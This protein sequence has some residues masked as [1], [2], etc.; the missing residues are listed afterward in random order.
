M[1]E[2]KRVIAL[3]FFDGVHLAHARLLR[4]VQNR[5]KE[6]GAKPC[7]FTFDIH[8]SLRLTGVQEPLLSS[9]EDR[10]QMMTQLFGMEEVIVASFDQ[11]MSMPWEDFV[12]VYLAKEQNAAHVVCGYDFRFGSHGAGDA[13]KLRQRCARRGIGCDIVGEIE[14]DGV[15][16][17]STHIR[18]LL[19]AGEMEEATRFLGHPHLL[20]GTV[21]QGKHL[22]HTLGF[23]TV[24][25]S[26]PE[27]VLVPAHGVYAAKALLPDGSTCL[28]AANI[29]VRPTV[30]ENAR[31]NVEAFLLDFDGNLY[32]QRVSLAFYHRLRGEVK[33]PDVAALTAE[34]LRNADQTRAYFALR[35]DDPWN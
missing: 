4:T 32:G 5:A 1:A 28:A 15:R 18:S 31:A 19:S 14:L 33:F 21:Q 2:R 8:P 17:S 30:E 20:S 34:V 27:G 7:A 22:G 9:V 13:D 12:D 16:V 23:P 25:L 29:G 11:M 35:E 24:N 3:G 10:R 6:L 26:F